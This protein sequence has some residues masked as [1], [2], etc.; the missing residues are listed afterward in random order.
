M[1]NVILT[2]DLHLT[3]APRDEYRWGLFQ[4]L[5]D[6]CKE[7]KVR[8][9]YI[10]GDLTDAKDFHSSALVNMVVQ[11]L[12]GLVEYADLTCINI[13]RGNHDSATDPE[14]P[15]F[16]FLNEIPSVAFIHELT[17]DGVALWLPHTRDAND[18]K[19]LN[20]RKFTEVFAHATVSGA[21]AE[22]EQVLEGI[23][24]SVFKGAG[25]VWS[26]DIHVPQTRGN[27]E[28]IGAPYPIRFGDKFKPRVVW[29]DDDGKP[30]D[31]HYPCLRR[32]MIE[33]RDDRDLVGFAVRRG[34]QVKVRVPLAR[35]E[36]GQ[37]KEAKQM[38]ETWARDQKVDLISVELVPLLDKGK[39][40]KKP[41]MQKRKSPEELFNE[42]C[43]RAKIAP[44]VAAAGRKML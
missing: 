8:Y 7:H 12:T 9:V 24:L 16:R 15:Y 32:W 21:V 18:W 10:L 3:T 22:N 19:W 44:T 14:W 43:T 34:D 38:V 36:Y 33:A 28:Y 42:Y 4:W 25:K 13:L 5:G 35:S 20:M 41:T 2:S 27:V 17:Q 31:L 23:P 26:G 37:W 6:E 29:I 30:H 40:T 11:A 1:R 39:P